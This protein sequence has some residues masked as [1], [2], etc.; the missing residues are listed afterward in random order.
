M[1]T[2]KD[3][4]GSTIPGHNGGV[5]EWTSSALTGYDGFVPSELY[6][7]Y[8]ADFFDG[9]HWVVLGGSYATVPQIARRAS[10]RNWYQGNYRY[11][12]IGAR[13]VYDA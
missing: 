12:W 5:W 13:V 9:K 1:P 6:P 2:T 8:S 11:A 4:S 10:F 3:H 7:G